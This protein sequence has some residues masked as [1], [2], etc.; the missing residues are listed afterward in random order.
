MELTTRCPNCETVF[1]VALEQLQL[2]KGYIRCIQCAHIFDAYEA[3]VPESRQ[4][5]PRV[6]QPPVAQPP[7]QANPRPAGVSESVPA[8]GG[9]VTGRDP[10][11]IP[12]PEQLP[13][14]SR[15]PARPFS[16]GPGGP[17]THREPAFRTPAVGTPSVESR[18][19][20][21]PRIPSVLRERGTR[22]G[23]ETNAP[24]FT[25]ADTR[26]LDIDVDGHP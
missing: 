3:V 8:S 16:I 5:E 12:P 14:Q 17:G 1:A 15:A 9:P 22:A 11:Y 24:S 25:I 2:R 6:S 20:E 13:D 18:L 26:P 19:P 21:E 7:V 4:A 23:Q 10:F